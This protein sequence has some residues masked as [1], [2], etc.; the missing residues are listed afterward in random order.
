MIKL[1]EKIYTNPDFLSIDKCKIIID[2]ISSGTKYATFANDK[3]IE[4]PANNLKSW[5][6]EAHE[7]LG[8]ARPRAVNLI[9]EFYGADKVW[10]EF[11][12]L[13]NLHGGDHHPLH[14]DN[15]RKDVNG[16]WIPN[17]TSQRNY[18]A[19]L[20]LNTSGSDFQGG[21]IVFPEL[22]QDIIPRSGLLIGFPSNRNFLHQT[23]PVTQGNR[24]A[25]SLWMTSKNE[26]IEKWN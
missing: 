12:L 7:I 20:Y 16:I 8:E 26:Y 4:I 17:H 23:T 9:R 2:A 22:G 25:V 21:H 11:T 18:S 6:Q 19:V 15:E 5:S 14:A 1:Q 24:F 13:S 10:N 3:R